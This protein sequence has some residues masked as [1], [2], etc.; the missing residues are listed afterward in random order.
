MR[1]TIAQQGAARLEAR[2]LGLKRYRDGRRCRRGHLGERY[3]SNGACVDCM[4]ERK[5]RRR[6]G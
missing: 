2:R 4:R 3:T 1:L 6:P 5:R